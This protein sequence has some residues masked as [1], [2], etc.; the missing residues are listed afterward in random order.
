MLCIYSE[1]EVAGGKGDGGK[2]LL[3]KSEHDPKGNRRNR[4]EVQ[5][6][7]YI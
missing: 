1:G 2:E 4:K 6:A 3:T 5:L 7:L